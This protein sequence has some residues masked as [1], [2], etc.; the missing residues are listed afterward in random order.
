MEYFATKNT[1]GTIRRI[2]EFPKPAIMAITFGIFLV[3]A[4]ADYLTGYEISC[5]VF[6]LL[7][8]GFAT[9]Y[10]GVP[11]GVFMSVLSAVFT[12]LFN[13]LTGQ[14]YPNHFVAV[15]DAAIVLSFYFVVVWLL[16]RL[17]MIQ[18][19]LEERI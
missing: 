17:R 13:V 14:K 7:A 9:W 2:E 16:H 15:W 1:V 18:D 19:T 12:S 6:Y 3:V 10:A 8:V 11:F 4:V 5:T